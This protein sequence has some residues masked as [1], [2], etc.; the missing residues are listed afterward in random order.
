MAEALKA[1]KD[2]NAKLRQQLTNMQ[3]E[4]DLERGARA[5]L[6]QELHYAARGLVMDFLWT[7]DGKNSKKNLKI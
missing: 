7:K 6:A 5:G 1:E 2:A 3:H 4:L